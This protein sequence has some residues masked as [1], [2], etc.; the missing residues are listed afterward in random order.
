M[1]WIGRRPVVYVSQPDLVGEISR[2][3]SFDIG[4][5]THLQKIQKPLFGGGIIKSNGA[6][7]AHQRKTIAPEFFPDKVKVQKKSLKLYETRLW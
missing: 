7:W 2:R 1:F 5:A 4:K 3:V 6:E